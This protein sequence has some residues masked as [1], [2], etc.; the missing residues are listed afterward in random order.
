MN[1]DGRELVSD[2]PATDLLKLAA[3]RPEVGKLF[4]SIKEKH[5]TYC[6]SV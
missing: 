6:W 1:Y 5:Y 3:S 2:L 4:L